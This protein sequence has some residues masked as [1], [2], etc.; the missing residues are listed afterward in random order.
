MGLA[1]CSRGPHSDLPLRDQ[2]RIPD[3]KPVLSTALPGRCL[4]QSPRHVWGG[5]CP[6]VH[7]PK[8]LGW[9]KALPEELGEDKGWQLCLG[10]QIFSSQECLRH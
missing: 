2:S 5:D 4:P 10:C 1:G 9:A 6:A 8:N 7:C 3:A